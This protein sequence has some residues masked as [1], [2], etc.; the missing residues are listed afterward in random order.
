[1]VNGIFSLQEPN[2]LRPGGTP[3]Q[4]TCNYHYKDIINFFPRFCAKKFFDNAKKLI[5]K[6]L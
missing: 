3:L 1:M 5:D 2:Q 6:D 4:L